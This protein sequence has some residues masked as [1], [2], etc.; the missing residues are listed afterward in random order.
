MV[1]FWHFPSIMR[2]FLRIVTIL[3]FASVATAVIPSSSSNLLQHLQ[4]QLQLQHSVAFCR[5]KSKC[6]LPWTFSMRGGESNSTNTDQDWEEYELDDEPGGDNQSEE[7]EE[8]DE[9]VG[10]SENDE[11]ENDQDNNSGNP[12]GEDID[13]EDPYNENLDSENLDSENLDSEDPES[14]NLDSEDPEI[15]TL[16]Q[17]DI[18]D[19]EE[20]EKNINEQ[21]DDILNEESWEEVDVETVEEQP[22]TT[23]TADL[24]V[25]D[26]DSSAFVDRE[27]LADAYDE[28]ESVVGKI[29][30]GNSES[31]DRVSIDDV[32]PPDDLSLPIH[33]KHTI[34]EELQ[35]EPETKDD[36]PV[37]PVLPKVE[38]DPD[39]PP[40]DNAQETEMETEKETEMETE[41]ET[42]METEADESIDPENTDAISF[43]PSIIDQ[44]TEEIL[45]QQCKYT[46][47]EVSMMKPDI[48]AVV[49][50]K[51]LQR[52]LEGMP[53][54]WIREGFS[55]QTNNCHRETLIRMAKRI[56]KA[57]FPVTLAALAIYGGLDIRN[58]IMSSESQK[59][60]IPEPIPIFNGEIEQDMVVTQEEGDHL[61]ESNHLTEVI[62]ESLKPGSTP[63]APK[64]ESWMDMVIT[65]VA[66]CFHAFWKLEI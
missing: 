37:D 34:K 40:K 23:T 48:A 14:E 8:L 42:E 35:L 25:T 13:N 33:E 60:I 49:A 6:H 47:T 61:A 31:D 43:I 38:A 63:K 2:V 52:P 18:D 56:P 55:T 21:A 64:D 12:I 26:D 36:K 4:Q 62:V 44:A 30:T 5:T 50:Q 39:L 45:I 16:S 1:R 51:R 9:T 41:I 46:K 10:E 57:V 29:Q 27:E 54:N 58:I 32:P 22:S 3:P 28:G 11:E 65:C 24:F 19:N 53:P 17:D 59:Q 7:F 15:V 66:N 20:N